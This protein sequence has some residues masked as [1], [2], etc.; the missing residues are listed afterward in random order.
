MNTE[1]ADSRFQSAV[2]DLH[3]R[4]RRANLL[5]LPGLL[6]V[7]AYFGVLVC[8]WSGQVSKEWAGEAALILLAVTWVS[9][10]PAAVGM[11]HLADWQCP[12]C[13]ASARPALYLWWHRPLRWWM[14]F[15]WTPRECLVCG[16]SFNEPSSTGGDQPGPNRESGS[17]AESGAPADRP[18]D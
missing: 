14:V 1:A 15:R 9:L 10:I 2:H 5:A 7:L 17:C 8:Y 11:W 4:W 3:R 16:V 13:G 12:A 18:R 6:A